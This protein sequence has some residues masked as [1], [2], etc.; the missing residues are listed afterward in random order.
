MI[1]R[2][3]NGFPLLNP[4]APLVKFNDLIK[5]IRTGKKIVGDRRSEAHAIQRFRAR[6]LSQAIGDDCCLRRRP[7][8]ESGSL[9]QNKLLLLHSFSPSSVVCSNPITETLSSGKFDSMP[10]ALRKSTI[11]STSHPAF[12]SIS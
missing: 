9:Y 6:Q 2:S 5:G 7:K 12:S 4:G 11:F 8:T 10:T 3:D 1:R